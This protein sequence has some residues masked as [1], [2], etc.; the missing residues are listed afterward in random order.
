MRKQKKRQGLGKV[1]IKKH[2][3][4]SVASYLVTRTVKFTKS[5]L[6]NILGLAKASFYYQDQQ[7]SKDEQ[8]KEQILSVLNLNPSYGH[9]RVALALDIGKKR[10]RRVMKKY[11]I[12]PYKRKRAW[13][14]R[15]DLR[16]PSAI[17]V[18]LVKGQCPLVPNHTW[19]SDFTYIRHQQRYIYLATF[20]DLYTR[21][22]IGW[23]ISNRHT[24]ELI[25]N[26]LLDGIKTNKL[27]M[28]QIIHSDQGSEV[29][30]PGLHQLS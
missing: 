29:Q 17:F 2:I 10:A 22:I 23:H 30:L 16:R 3:I 9:R 7:T 12:K 5:Q 15:R 24:K 20:M 11:G 14:K 4:V 26:A 27:R 25:L 21:E 28:P 1:E 8:L 6:I 13:K 18:N 19:V